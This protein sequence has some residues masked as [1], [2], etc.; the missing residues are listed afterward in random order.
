MVDV[1]HAM[2]ADDRELVIGL[3]SAVVACF[4]ILSGLTDA[5]SLQ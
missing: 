2:L 1:W 5:H 4:W 3:E